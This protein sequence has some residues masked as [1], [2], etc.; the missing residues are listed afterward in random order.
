[1]LPLV[2]L[3][4]TGLLMEYLDPIPW[5]RQIYRRL[6]TLWWVKACGTMAFMGVFFAAYFAVLRHPLFPTFSMPLTPF[7]A[8]VPVS[9]K[10]FPVYASLWV[11]VSLPPALLL[12][13]RSLAMFCLWIAALCL[14]CLGI[15]WVL[16]T[17]VPPADVDWSLYPEMAMIKGLDAAGNACPSLHVASA[18]FSAC[19]LA[20]LLRAVLAPAWLSLLNGLYCL[21]ILWSTLAT[22]QHV[23]LDV[24]AGILVGG[25]FALLSLRHAGR[26]TEEI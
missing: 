24:L 17:M 1:M 6:T 2:I 4:A 19:W 15:F 10:A 16:P 26:V 13:F 20:R 14:F 18:V 25:G 5:Y 7:D 9:A 8:W 23:V 3:I 22:R 12:R 11:Y 21:A